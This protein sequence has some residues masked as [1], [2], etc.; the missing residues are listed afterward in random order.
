MCDY[1]H[2]HLPKYLTELQK[3]YKYPHLGRRS[4]NSLAHT[5]PLTFYLHHLL[6]HLVLSANR[7]QILSKRTEGRIPYGNFC[8]LLGMDTHVKEI[9]NHLHC[10]QVMLTP[11][12]V[13]SALLPFVQRLQ[14]RMLSLSVLSFLICQSCQK[15]SII[16]VEL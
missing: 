11:V 5:S 1:G 2:L 4:R 9:T 14:T 3:W 6:K 13:T 7:N 10:F 8:S 15:I 12:A 16:S